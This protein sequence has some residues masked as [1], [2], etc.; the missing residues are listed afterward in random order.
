MRELPAHGRCSASTAIAVFMVRLFVRSRGNRVPGGLLGL[1]GAGCDLIAG[2][3]MGTRRHSPSWFVILPVP[4]LAWCCPSAVTMSHS[5][6]DLNR[7]SSPCVQRTHGTP[8]CPAS[9]HTLQSW[10]LLLPRCS[11]PE[12]SLGF[13]ASSHRPPGC[14]WNHVTATSPTPPPQELC[15]TWGQIL[16]LLNPFHFCIPFQWN[17][18]TRSAF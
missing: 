16:G 3:R 12:A 1:Y 11:F 4:P 2:S 18:C 9:A 17:L 10:A 14:L 5:A 8:S 6:Q 7:G 13:C 15:R